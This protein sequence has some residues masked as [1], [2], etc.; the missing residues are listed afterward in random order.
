MKCRQSQNK[1][2]FIRQIFDGI[3]RNGTYKQ[4]QIQPNKKKKL[5]CEFSQIEIVSALHEKSINELFHFFEFFTFCFCWFAVYFAFFKKKK[6]RK[7]L[8]FLF[9]YLHSQSLSFLIYT[10][11]FFRSVNEK[12]RL[13]FFCCFSC[14]SHLFRRVIF[15][16][17]F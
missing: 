6:S 14:V 7:I 16:I 4:Q 9:V 15:L 17:H 11:S 2:K 1:N 10:F 13:F 12:I 8:C 5:M 3:F